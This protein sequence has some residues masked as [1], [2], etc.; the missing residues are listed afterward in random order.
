MGGAGGRDHLHE[1]SQTHLSWMCGARASCAST[2]PSFR[3]T[4]SFDLPTWRISR[5]MGSCPNAAEPSNGAG[6][7]ESQARCPSPLLFSPDAGPIVY[8]NHVHPER[9]TPDGQSM[10]AGCGR[11]GVAARMPLHITARLTRGTACGI[12]E[13]CPVSR[14]TQA[15]ATATGLSPNRIAIST[16]ALASG[17][18]V[19][20]APLR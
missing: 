14:P 6:L 17:S 18:S 12:Y 13:P 16:A 2:S 8:T 5:S 9:E 4:F 1:V 20:S 15:A 19:P 3:V 10:P 7:T 11:A